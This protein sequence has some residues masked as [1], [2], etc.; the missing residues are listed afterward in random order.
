[1]PEGLLESAQ[2][3]GAQVLVLTAHANADGVRVVH[4]D[5]VGPLAELTVARL[6]ALLERRLREAPAA[7]H[8]WHLWRS[9]LAE[10]A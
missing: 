7:W 3:T 8:F 2:G 10:P 1:M 4:A 5:A 6:A 9:F